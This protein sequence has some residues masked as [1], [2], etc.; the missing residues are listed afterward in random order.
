MPG[1]IVN[2]ATGNARKR[3][4][5]PYDATDQLA[6]DIRNAG[7][8]ASKMGESEDDWQI[9][10]FHAVCVFANNESWLPNVLGS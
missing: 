5:P 7:S 3:V 1:P 2:K 10:L 6:Q 9:R 8:K 4:Q